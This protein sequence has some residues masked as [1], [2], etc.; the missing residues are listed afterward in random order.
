MESNN[1]KIYCLL[2]GNAHAFQLICFMFYNKI[3]IC[4]V[5]YTPAKLINGVKKYNRSRCARRL[6]RYHGFYGVGI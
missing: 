2:I 5:E 1:T 3:W 6:V 4:L